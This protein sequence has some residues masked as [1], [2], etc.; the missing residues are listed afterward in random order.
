MG[1]TG[2]VEGLAPEADQFS[3]LGGGGQGDGLFVAA[4]GGII[5]GRAAVG[6]GPLDE[7][8]QPAEHGQ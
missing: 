8:A 6:L 1:S 5:A 7:L 3:G 4:D 2:Q